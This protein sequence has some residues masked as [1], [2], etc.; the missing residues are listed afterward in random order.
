MKNINAVGSKSAG[1]RNEKLVIGLLRDQGALSQAQICG[2]T[3]FGS[4]TISYIVGRLREKGLIIEQPGQSKKRGAKPTLIDINPSGQYI[5]GTEINPSFLSIGLFNFK[6]ELVDHIKVAL[7]ASHSVENVLHLTE[8]NIKGLLSK[9][10]I[11]NDKLSGI[12][13]TLSGSIS[14]AGSVQLSSP[15]GWKNVPLKRLLSEKFDCPVV[16]YTTNVRLLAELNVLPPLASKNIVYLNVANGVG[17][18]IMIDGHLIHGSTNR[19]GELGHVVIDPEGPLCGCGHQ[20]CLEAFISGPSLASKMKREIASG[21][22]SVL[23]GLITNLDTPETILGKLNQ[24]IKQDDAYALAIREFIAEH[25]SRSAA[26]AINL[27]D[28]DILLL[29]GY[30]SETC[31]EYFISH[32]KKCFEKYVYDES[33]RT[34]EI[35]HA[36]A[37]QQSMI[38]SVAVAVLRGL[39]TLE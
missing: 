22:S 6:S 29:G 19:C 13:C 24:A 18:T 31:I 10:H 4:S 9:H 14:P 30:V 3:G 32:I 33:S 12:G 17:T 35:I 25:I 23:S 1:I 26:T 36:R 20:G 15:L 27:F 34:I 38:R 11:A 7:D 2:K 16:V 39:F 5:I 28:P 37:G 8:V 21:T